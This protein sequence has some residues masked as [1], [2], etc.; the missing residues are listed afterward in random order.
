MY[1]SELSHNILTGVYISQGKGEE[2]LLEIG[3]SNLFLPHSCTVSEEQTRIDS[4]T[5]KCILYRHNDGGVRLLQQC[6]LAAY[7]MFDVGEALAGYNF[8][9]LHKGN[10]NTQ[11]EHA[12]N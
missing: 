4:G 5:E 10:W 1:L 12:R 9:L 8:G 7:F 3:G 11:V 6:P 2:F